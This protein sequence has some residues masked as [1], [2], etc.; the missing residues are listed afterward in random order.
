VEKGGWHGHPAD[1][2]LGNVCRGHEQVHPVCDSFI[3]QVHL[4][5][6]ART[7]TIRKRS[8]VGVTRPPRVT[9]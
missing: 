3:E 6:E 1:A 5:T 2:K 4:L 8:R 9:E 7:A